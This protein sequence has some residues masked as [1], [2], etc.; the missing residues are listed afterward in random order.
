M[1]VRSV[2]LRRVVQIGQT[3]PFALRLLE[4]GLPEC[5]E[6]GKAHFEGVA[7]GDGKELEYAT[8]LCDS[9]DKTVQAY[10][11]EFVESRWE[12]L[13]AVELLRK[14]SEHSDPQI[15]ELVAGKLL[16]SPHL[17]GGKDATKF[18]K[19]ILRTHNQGRRV[20]ELVKARLNQAPQGQL[21]QSI[22]LE[23]A[24]S[25]TQRDAEW[26]FEQLVRLAKSGE[27]IEGLQ[28]EGVEGI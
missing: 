25:W 16:T 22:L 26:A 23:M 2:A 8:V 20:K 7:A 9:P 11:R 13:P 14:L 3:T 12:N 24:R 17:L 21:D 4:S 27:I 1:E 10:G 19:G 15:Q 5:I 6:R 18:D 28:V